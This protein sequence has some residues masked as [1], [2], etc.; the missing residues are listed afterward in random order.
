MFKLISNLL[1]SNNKMEC[2]MLTCKLK[3]NKKCKSCCVFRKCRSF[4]DMRSLQK[5]LIIANEKLLHTVQ[6]SN[7][8]KDSKTFVDMVTKYRDDIVIANFNKLGEKPG[9]EEI[10]KFLDENFHE[11]GHDLVHVEPNDW[12]EYAPFIAKLTDPKLINF[13]GYLNSKWKT[14]IRNF[15]RSKICTECTSTA[16][17]SKNSFIVPGGR[18]I[19]YYYW[20]TYWC[21]EGLLSSGM[22]KT[23]KGIIENF[24]DIVKVNGF[25]PNGSRVY[26]LN[27]SQPPMLTQMVNSYFK[28]T[29]DHQFLS[30]S[31]RELDVE[32]EYWM[33]KKS[34]VLGVKGEFFRLNCYNVTSFN[35]RPESYKEDYI[36][37]QN[38]LNKEDYFS[39]IITATESGWDFSSRWFEDPY[40]IKTIQIKNIIPVDLNAIMYKNE[41]C[42]YKFHK[43]LN[44]GKDKYYEQAIRRRHKAINSVFW[45]KKLNT[46]GDFNLKKNRVNNNF[47]YISDLSPLWSGIKPP[48]DPEIILQRYKSLLYSHVSGIPV[49]N[50]FSRQQWDFPNVWAPYNYWM[51]YYL[52][53]SGRK[54]QALN[55]AQRFVNTVYHGWLKTNYIFEK[56]EADELGAYGG[57]GEYIVQE[58][59]GWTNGVVV[60][61]LDWFGDEIKLIEPRDKENFDELLLCR[62]E[63]FEDLLHEPIER[64]MA[65]VEIE[66]Y[67][68]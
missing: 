17:F 10:K 64:Q 5:S 63:C 42:L 6:M 32:Y 55:I 33:T 62:E 41:L 58:G 24:L 18:F 35:P 13:A 25:V 37:A 47:L 46:W 39:N 28:A 68:S 9:I 16:L 4:S 22:Q 52:R 29:N 19:E 8:Y 14:L 51:V 43:I 34:T 11:V 7:V 56:Y 3:N 31:I 59:F 53:L 48:V 36:N 67:T 12:Y 66:K 65:A 15:D 44:T 1:M 57:G 20:D 61:L 26:Y 49:S 45:N 38:N 21:I 60:K 40:D 2:K 30:H 54:E 27:R 23:A 50:V